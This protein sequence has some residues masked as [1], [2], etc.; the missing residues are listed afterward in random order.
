[1]REKVR[2]EKKNGKVFAY[3]MGK[4]HT[5]IETD[6]DKVAEDIRAEGKIVEYKE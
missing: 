2:I 4:E 6:I 3:F 5:M 1:M